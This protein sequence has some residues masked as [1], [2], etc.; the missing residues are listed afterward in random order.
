MEEIIYIL[1]ANKGMY[2]NYKTWIVSIHRTKEGLEISKNNFLKEN[3]R[4][5][6]IHEENKISFTNLY[7][8]KED[9]ETKFNEYINK[10]GKENYKIISSVEFND[11]ANLN[12][13]KQKL[14]D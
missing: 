5:S 2:D 13:I 12:I 11:I 9:K 7:N 1:E 6:K 3:D 8:E 10:I 14:I 4:R